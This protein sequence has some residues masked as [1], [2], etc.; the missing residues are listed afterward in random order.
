MARDKRSIWVF[1]VNALGL[2]VFGT[3]FTDP[4]PTTPEPPHPQVTAV[5]TTDHLFSAGLLISEPSLKSGEKAAVN[6]LSK[7]ALKAVRAA[8]NP[9]ECSIKQAVT[10]EEIRMAIMLDTIQNC[11]RLETISTEN[12]KPAEHDDK[13]PF[14]QEKDFSFNEDA[15]K[16]VAAA[17]DAGDKMD[18][19]QTA[20]EARSKEQLL[21]EIGLHG[22]LYFRNAIKYA[23]DKDERGDIETLAAKHYSVFIDSLLQL[24]STVTKKEKI[25]FQEERITIVTSTVSSTAQVIATMLEFIS[26]PNYSN[27]AEATN[28]IKRLAGDF[29]DLMKLVRNE[30]KTKQTIIQSPTLPPL[31]SSNQPEKE[32]IKYIISSIFS[33]Q[34]KDDL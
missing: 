32:V 17:I 21:Q 2:G 30:N 12:V 18:A 3:T 1:A 25:S 28:A 29:Y 34:K 9:Q 20:T 26:R 7:K 4:N 24:A 31:K 22:S 33:K 6:E 15:Q 19:E 27:N 5:D 8:F 14:K 23:T 10:T 13:P 16:V 11:Y